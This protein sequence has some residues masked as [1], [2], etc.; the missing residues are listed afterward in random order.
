[1]SKLHWTNVTHVCQMERN[2][3][4]EELLSKDG[5]T[6]I[7]LRLL[8]VRC[9]L[10]RLERVANSLGLH[11]AFNTAWVETYWTAVS[12]G[13]EV[14]RDF[15]EKVL[16]GIEADR[17]NEDRLLNRLLKTEEGKTIEAI[18]ESARPRPTFYEIETAPEN[19]NPPTS[20]VTPLHYGG[21]N[22]EFETIKVLFA[23]GIGKEFCIGNAIKYISRMGKKEEA[24]PEMDCKKAIKYLQL[25]LANTAEGET[26][27]L[28]QPRKFAK[29]V[30]FKEWGLQGVGLCT[31]LVHIFAGEYKQAI[32]CLK[33]Y[34]E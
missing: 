4:V 29:Q 25:L 33:K 8:G 11:D 17:E 3:R 28:Y 23:A 12:G 18:K 21:C 2:E 22:N 14:A 26:V 7:R 31:A 20:P 5:L 34:V 19:T 10:T 13:A 32:E 6:K 1:M 9:Y 16:E 27:K 24:A 30:L 15:A